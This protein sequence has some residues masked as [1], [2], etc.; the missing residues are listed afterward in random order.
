LQLTFLL[1]RK[2]S[3]LHRSCKETNLRSS[4]LDVLFDLFPDLLV[5]VIFV[6]DRVFLLA[7]RVVF[8]WAELVFVLLVL[9]MVQ[10]W[11]VYQFLLKMFIVL[12]LL[13]KSFSPTLCSHRQ[14]MQQNPPYQRSESRN[15]IRNS[16]ES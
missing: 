11:F 8:N 12:L 16:L 3:F 2:L 7:E 5:L 9:G 6:P 14:M 1:F 15:F 4:S 10:F 13:F